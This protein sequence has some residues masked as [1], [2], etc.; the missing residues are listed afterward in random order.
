MSPAAPSLP[1]LQHA[2]PQKAMEKED[3]FLRLA[4]EEARTA[5]YCP[6]VELLCNPDERVQ[7]H[8]Q[9]CEHCRKLY[10]E[11]LGDME[12]ERQAAREIFDIIEANRDELA[13]YLSQIAQVPFEPGQV[14]RLKDDALKDT[15][16]GEHWNNAPFVLVLE[17]TRIDGIVRVAQIG[18][19]FELADEGDVPISG[20]EYE[21]S[22]IEAW[23]TYPA[24]ESDLGP[25]LSTVEP[26]VVEDVRSLATASLASVASPLIQEFRD[27][28]LGIGRVY[29]KKAVTVHE[30]L[31]G[32]FYRM[33]KKV[34]SWSEVLTGDVA[35]IVD[36]VTGFASDVTRGAYIAGNPA[37]AL[38]ADRHA[39]D[40]SEADRLLLDDLHGSAVS[41]EV[42]V[43]DLTSLSSAH[44]P[45]RIDAEFRIRD[46]ELHVLL[47]WDGGE[48]LDTLV[49][50]DKT[51]EEYWVMPKVRDD[52]L[53][54]RL[55]ECGA[56]DIGEIKVLIFTVSKEQ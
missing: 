7:L 13:E 35:A 3:R 23:N 51:G 32:A 53:V 31:Q 33:L 11:L 29:S 9:D 47:N 17:K 22:F 41:G 56:I 52:L 20:N 18:E 48:I 14:R 10:E 21:N 1:Y 30:C 42:N 26:S 46:E 27:M 15:Y 55:D 19:G 8:M 5:R 37:I 34:A 36:K 28:E 43:F 6:P 25:V 4:L 39:V 49:L 38:A 2:T 50:M 12:K 45:R 24:R 40:L 16:D 44:H 54:F